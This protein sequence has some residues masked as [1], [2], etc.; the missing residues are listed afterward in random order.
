MVVTGMCT[1]QASMPQICLP[2]VLQHPCS[3]VKGYLYLN[4]LSLVSAEGWLLCR[5]RDGPLLPASVSSASLF[6]MSSSVGSQHDMRKVTSTSSLQAMGSLGMMSVKSVQEARSAAV[7]GIRA[8]PDKPLELLYKLVSLMKVGRVACTAD[9]PAQLM[10]GSMWHL[11]MA[12]QPNC[13][14]LGSFWCDC[15]AGSC[16]CKLIDPRHAADPSIMCSCCR[17]LLI[18]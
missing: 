15:T 11:L 16:L 8:M 5:H 6:A 1:T 18:S 2:L 13:G 12:C 9:C 3:R 4:Y 10:L 14:A 17:L 7:A